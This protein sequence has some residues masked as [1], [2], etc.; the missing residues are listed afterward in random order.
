MLAPAQFAFLKLVDRRLWYALHS[1]GFPGGQNRAEQ[2]NPRIEAVGAR[3]H[4]AA[5]CDLGRPLTEPSLERALAVIRA[6][7]EA[8]PKTPEP[9]AAA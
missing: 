4:W 9:Q 3:D 6:K 2:P 1:L 7:T 8:S 5:E